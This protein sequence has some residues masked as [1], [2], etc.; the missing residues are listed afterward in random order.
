[1]DRGVGAHL[2]FDI[3]ERLEAVSSPYQQ[4]D[5]FRSRGFG[6]VLLI[7]GDLQLTERDEA[8]YHE[9][10]T[11][12]PLAYMPPD[13]RERA[14]GRV[15]IVGGGDGGVVCQVLKHLWVAEVVVV[16]IDEE[17]IAVA[18]R[19][20]PQL[21]RCLD[22]PRVSIVH[23]DAAAW[24]Q[25]AE[26][27]FDAALADVTDF[28]ASDTLRTSNFLK[29]LRTKARVVTINLTSLAWNLRKAAKMVKAFRSVFR[30][31]RAY[32][33]AQ[34]TYVS[35]FYGL[36]VASVEI[37]ALEFGLVDWTAMDNLTV[38]CFYYSP[39]VHRAAFALPRYVERVLGG[40]S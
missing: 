34:P 9:M 4:I 14:A 25:E 20:F 23:A 22:D 32:A 29:L 2:V 1:M 33:I 19:H 5:V 38:E 16:D 24:L 27:T 11:H 17:V 21:G 36:L 13:A 30:Y 28:G 18:K 37:D 7:D 10:M 12:V 26:G 31:V 40:N 8:S 6:K 3:L 39:A 15:L 35:G